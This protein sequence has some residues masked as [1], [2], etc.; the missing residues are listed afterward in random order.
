MCYHSRHFNFHTI[1][2]SITHVLIMSLCILM[3][4]QNTLR[5]IYWPGIAGVTCSASSNPQSPGC[6]GFTSAVASVS[7]LPVPLACCMGSELKSPA[8]NLGHAHCSLSKFKSRAKSQRRCVWVWGILYGLNM[9]FTFW[10]GCCL[11]H[12][13]KTHFQ[14]IWVHFYLI[15]YKF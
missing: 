5:W 9:H 10:T 3:K 8:V 7:G 14:R 13:I 11:I 2:C 4:Q 6:P 12:T 1:T 15:K